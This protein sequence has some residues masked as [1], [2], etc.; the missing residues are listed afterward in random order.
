MTIEILT[1]SEAQAKGLKHY[2]TGKPC[3]SGHLCERYTSVKTCVACNRNHT[4]RHRSLKPEWW[5][6]RGSFYYAKHPEKRRASCASW[7]ENNR[8][9]ASQSSD[10]WR[11]RNLAKDAARSAGRRALA[12]QA[13]LP[14][15]SAA[16]LEIYQTCPEGFHVDHIVPLKGESVCGLHVPWNLQHLPASENIKKSNQFK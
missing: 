6:E 12:K 10:A 14:G 1:R 8:L 13:T 5:L 2:F 16:I 7:R 9:K 3:K 11:R 15:H 4:R